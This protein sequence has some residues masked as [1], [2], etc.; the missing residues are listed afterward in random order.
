MGVKPSTDLVL[1]INGI[2]T[3][4][5]K[6]CTYLASIVTVDGGALEDVHCRMKKGNGTLMQLYPV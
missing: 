1:T 3:E 2:Q 5:V 6:S 4:Q